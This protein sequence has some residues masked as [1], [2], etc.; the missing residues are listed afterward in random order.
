MMISSIPVDPATRE[1]LSN[2]D[3]FIA[4][5]AWTP[6]GNAGGFSGARLW[7]GQTPDGRR[8]CLREWPVAR[9]TADRLFDIHQA[10]Q[11]LA[12]LPFVPEI[13]PTLDGSTWVQVDDACWE[14]TTWMPGTADFHQKPTNARLFAAMRTLAAMHSCLR[15]DRE[16]STP[17]PAVKRI[18]RALRGWRDLLQ[19]GWQP[20]FQLPRPNRSPR[21]R[22]PGLAGHLRRHLQH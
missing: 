10:M 22:A 17:C 1:V 3:G 6:L 18:L 7:R 14:I 15:P 19:S 12:E 11:V 20:D 5:A 4:G 21:S 16:R 2:Y 9:T 13:W 8:L